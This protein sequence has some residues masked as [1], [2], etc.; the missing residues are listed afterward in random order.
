MTDYATRRTVIGARRHH[1]PGQA[2][3]TH[4][5]SLQQS[6]LGVVRIGYQHDRWIT[7]RDSF[8]ADAP[9]MPGF[10]KQSEFAL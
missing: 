1:G 8:D 5:L 2:W 10:E 7:W 9:M 4:R 3:R 6:Q